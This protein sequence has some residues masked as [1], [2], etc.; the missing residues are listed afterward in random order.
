MKDII[1]ILA[2]KA[3]PNTLNGVNKVV[4]AIATEQTRM[5]YETLVVGIANNTEQR[6]HPQYD[7]RLFCKSKNPLNY[8]HQVLSFLVS[9]STPNTVFHFHSVFILWFLPLIKDLK[10]NNRCRI[11]LTPHGQYVNEAMKSLKK[12]ICFSL[13]DKKVL[14]EISG[15]HII[16][17]HTENNQWIQKYVQKII[18]IPNG[19]KLT[20]AQSSTKSRELVFGYMGRLECRQKGLDVLIPAFIDYILGGG[21]GILR[22]AGAGPDEKKLRKLVQQSGFNDRIVFEGKLFDDA[23]WQFLKNCSFFLHLSRWE[24]L[25]TACLEAASIGTPLLITKETNLDKYI[26]KYNAGL[27]IESI[28][29]NT[30]IKALFATERISNTPEIEKIR[31]NSTAMIQEEFNWQNITQKIIKNLYELK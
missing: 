28:D 17:Y 18:S 22:I 30:I 19:I 6:H 26:Q 27:V 10:K 5:G 11:F 15:I 14:R 2:G 24:G 29:K 16:G 1:H 8:P 7:Y 9:Q 21:N 23:K 25:P 4:D 13:F 3:N 20:E 31:A 12:R